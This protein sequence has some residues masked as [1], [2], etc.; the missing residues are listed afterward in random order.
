MN[1]EGYRASRPRDD[2]KVAGENTFAMIN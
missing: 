2:I 1:M